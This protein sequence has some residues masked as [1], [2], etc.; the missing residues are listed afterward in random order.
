MELSDINLLDRDAFT[1]GVPHDW[2][3]YLRANHPVY[4][5][6]EPDGPGFWVITKY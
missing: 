4:R 2:F 5:H 6:P 3:T 1:K